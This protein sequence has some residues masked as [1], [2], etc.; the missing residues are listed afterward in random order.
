MAETHVLVHGAWHGAWCWAGVMRQLEAGGD[1]AYAVDLPAHGA[2]RLDPARATRAGYVESVVRFIEER[3]LRNVVL[4]GH[5]LGGMT[6]AG[7]AERIPER[8]KRVVFATALVISEDS[9]AF[10]DMGPLMPASA[11]AHIHGLAEGAAAFTLSAERFRAA[12][13]Q[14][15]S[16]G[17]QDFVLSALVPEPSAPANE[18]APLRDFHR[19]H[20][21]TG[22]LFCENDMVFDDP[23]KWRV[24]ASKLRNPATRSIKSGHELMFTHPVETARAL[25]ELARA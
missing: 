9:S 19:S 25:A 22:Y 23:A 1:I 7:V 14:D 15:G 2:D 5:S 24:F 20:I 18:K 8:I 10:E 3:N 16:A 17:L 13:L 21:P 4:S 12:F 6:I 11:Q